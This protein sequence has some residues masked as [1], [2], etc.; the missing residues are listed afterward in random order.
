MSE[1]IAI[2]FTMFPILFIIL[3]IR[4]YRMRKEED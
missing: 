1:G 2:S 3:F 4:F